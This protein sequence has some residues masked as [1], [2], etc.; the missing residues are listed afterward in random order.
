MNADDLRQCVINSGYDPTTNSTFGLS[1]YPRDSEFYGETKDHLWSVQH[2][3]G[4]MCSAPD[5]TLYKADTYLNW[6]VPPGATAP[7]KIGPAIGMSETYQVYYN[8]KVYRAGH[9]YSSAADPTKPGGYLVITLD[10][11]TGIET[12]HDAGIYLDGAGPNWL[13]PTTGQWWWY[14]E[15]RIDLT[16][17]VPVGHPPFGGVENNQGPTGGVLDRLGFAIRLQNPFDQSGCWINGKGYFL[18]FGPNW[19]R[20]IECET[21]TDGP[22]VWTEIASDI[23]DLSQPNYSYGRFFAVQRLNALM[24]LPGSTTDARMFML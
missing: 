5:G 19:G 13:D 16:G 10:P 15:Q 18:G 4:M 12:W 1:Y 22:C 9:F 6:K 17:S 8:G 14:G 2:T 21:H 3:Y 24:L 23:G 20:L 7:I 11:A